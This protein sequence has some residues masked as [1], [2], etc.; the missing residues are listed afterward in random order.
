MD[1]SPAFIKHRREFPEGAANEAVDEVRRKERKSSALLKDTRYRWLKNPENLTESQQ[2]T[3]AKLKDCDLDT[4]KA[5]RMRL[6]LQEVYR[7]PASI[8][9]MV[10]QDWIQWG[11]RCR[12]TPMVEV[13][14]ML[15][16]HY[17][18]VVP[19]IPLQYLVRSYLSSISFSCFPSTLFP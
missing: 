13:A 1:M 2:E 5:Y 12:L 10:L 16:K 6:I 15:Q 18:G 9:P 8:A 4:A 7:Y 19:C 14:K 11:L 3:I 17:D